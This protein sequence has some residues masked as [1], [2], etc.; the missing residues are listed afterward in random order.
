MVSTLLLCAGLIAAAPDTPAA[1]DR[2][3]YEAAV[4]K[5]GRDAD[6]HVKLALWCE[7]HGLEAERA[8]HLALAALL[9]PKNALARSLMGLVQFDGHWRR[10][11]DI[12]AKIQ[13]DVAGEATRAEY[14][15]KR[16]RTPQTADAHWKLA[17]WCDEN[18]LK[19]EATAHLWAVIRLDPNRDAAW[20]RLGYKKQGNRWVTDAQL[21]AAKEERA[22]KE[23]ADRRWK[24]LLEKWRG[25]L[26]EKGTRRDEAEQ[27]LAG[28]TDPR[29]EPMVWAVFARGNEAN[30]RV[31]VRVLGQIDAPA[32]TRDLALLALFSPSAE[33][34]RTAAETIS[35]RD[36]RGYAGLLIGFLAEPIKYQVRPVNGPGSRGELFIEGKE[37]N[38][39]RLY[40]PPSGP[41][42]SMQPTDGLTYDANGLPII[43]R[44][45]FLPT[46][47]APYMP[48]LQFNTSE[49][50]QRLS[51]LLASSGMTTT[52]SWPAG[53]TATNNLQQSGNSL[54]PIPGGV[55][56]PGMTR[57]VTQIPVG[58]MILQAQTV[59]V[60]AE[61][62]LENDAQALDRYNAP[63]HE[64]NGRIVTILKRSSGQDFGT[65]RNA[66]Q[67]WFVDFLGLAAEPQRASR[68]KPLLVD[69]VP[70]V[71]QAQPIP[72]TSVVDASNLNV[73]IPGNTSTAVRAHSSC[74]GRGT[75]VHSLNGQRPI[76]KILLGDQVLTLD[77][78]SGALSYQ[79]VLRAVQNP[80]SKTFAI[81]VGGETI[82]ATPIHRFWK[83]AVGWV[84]ARDLKPGDAIRIF[85]GS[86]RV[87]AIDD[88][89]VQ[90]VF[91][92]DVASGQSFFVGKQGA[93]VH[94]NSLAQAVPE[95]FD[96]PAS[97]VGTIAS[98]VAP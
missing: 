12:A 46:G 25:G 88:A 77:P 56:V 44:Q 47:Y 13:A 58:A 52:Q 82:V 75:L 9:D 94:D 48:W 98:N 78:Q 84:M 68:D 62:Q 30:Q 20:K 28:I 71:V 50:S 29:A 16:V 5:A 34:R 80:P 81:Q 21:A 64:L 91:N 70:L 37:A 83:T 27:A 65:D 49:V 92:L 19:A 7:Q 42:V 22:L 11:E 3:A 54:M 55:N 67:R 40:S 97:V 2:T 66:W 6:A 76:E 41:T 63:I 72:V 74:F 35:Q 14:N 90:P 69:E 10:P 86:A 73:P 96:M 93:L 95:P 87:T 51:G 8:K 57:I 18:G 33:V 17:L 89:P 36:L 39:R 23:K 60:A 26:S 1:I 79:P 45:W 4:A 24:P 43:A 38:L 31:A 32:S 15:E 53:Q 85:G 59:A 61:E